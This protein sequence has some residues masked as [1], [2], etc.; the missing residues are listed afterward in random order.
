M[1]KTDN[2]KSWNE[3]MHGGRRNK[4]TQDVIITQVLIKN[5]M[6]QND[7]SVIN[8][9]LDAQKFYDRIFPSVA[10][11]CLRKMGLPLDIGITIAKT[12]LNMKH[13]VNTSHGLSRKSITSNDMPWSGYFQ[14]SGAAGPGWMAVEQTMLNCYEKCKWYKTN[15]S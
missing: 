11:I 2:T 15:E 8:V 13:K 4:T 5:I 10:T 6:Q 14:G 9:S 7:T 3:E 1:R 12:I